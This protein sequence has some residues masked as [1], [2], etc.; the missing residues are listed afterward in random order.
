MEQITKL[1]RSD[2]IFKIGETTRDVECAMPLPEGNYI[3]QSYT[4]SVLITGTEPLNGECVVRGRVNF[5]V[6][7]S[8]GEAL[9]SLDYFADFDTK[10]QGNV[11]PTMK[12]SSRAEIADLYVRTDDDHVTGTA[13]ACVTLY[14]IS[15]QEIP[16]IVDLDGACTKQGTATTCTLMGV[17]D[18]KTTLYD[19]FDAGKARNVVLVGSG[20]T[21]TGVRC[22][23]GAIKVLGEAR[24]KVLY[25][26]DTGAY[27]H[28]FSV[29][30]TEEI[31]AGGICESC[32]AT[33]SACVENVKLVLA[34]T[35]D[36]TEI[37]AE[38]SVYVRSDAWKCEEIDVIED[39]FCVECELD[40]E[41]CAKT[42]S[43]AKATCATS[44]E[45]KRAVSLQGDAPLIDKLVGPVSE[46]NVTTALTPAD[47]EITLEGVLSGA[48]LYTCRNGLIQSL[49][50]E[51]PYVLTVPCD[52]VQ[53][54]DQVLGS[55]EIMD[56]NARARG[57][58]EIE[59]TFELKLST[60]I[61]AGSVTCAVTSCKDGAPRC[62]S[63][64]PVT[65]RFG[66]KGDE[67]FDTAKRLAIA[68]ESLI[69]A[70]PNLTFPLL[71]GEKIVEYHP[72]VCE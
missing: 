47:G 27:V 64:H 31:E 16:A 24:A 19:E 14:G 12:I 15:V 4:A 70:N 35:E 6:I 10:V 55:V 52:E 41:R 40:L 34:G 38:I 23:D 46:W 51:L 53:N 62:V 30:F 22:A 61:Y 3:P 5:K 18:T 7:I 59:L 66:Q 44:A 49:P 33:A 56:A 42:S 71:G 63:N 69:E 37:R 26:T 36:D 8:D 13:T 65:V 32:T 17:F 25:T 57:E 1:I 58:S 68:P 43:C 72:I 20:A 11:L 67:L 60:C 50:Y 2:Y 9:S 54:T 21:V 39:A 29:P 28:T 48:V 45:V